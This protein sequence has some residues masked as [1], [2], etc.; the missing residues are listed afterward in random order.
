MSKQGL[1]VGGGGGGG[2]EVVLKLMYPVF[3]LDFL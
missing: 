3:C 1:C 2:E